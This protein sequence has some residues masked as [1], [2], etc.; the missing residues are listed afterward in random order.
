MTF[1]NPIYSRNPHAQVT[2]RRQG[3]SFRQDWRMTDQPAGISSLYGH[4]PYEYGAVAPAGA[5]LFTAGACPLDEEGKV[6]GTG[7]P[8]A[9]A[10]VSLENL[11]VVLDGYGARPEHLV[12]TTVYV[13]GDRP[14][15][16]AV[17]KVVADGLAPSRPPSTLLGVSALGYPGQLVEIE[18]I[19]ALPDYGKRGDS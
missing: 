5:L 16:V 18:G 15:L 1:T 2:V 9:Q 8:V 7:D 14:D 3:P 10:R 6:V 13:V 12:K 17:W 11:I 4:A 19:A